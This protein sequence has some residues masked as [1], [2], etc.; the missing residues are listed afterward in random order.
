[1]MQIFVKTPTGET[2]TLEVESCAA[3]D[4]VKAKIHDK[5]GTRPPPS[6][7]TPVAF[8]GAGCVAALFV[9]LP[10]FRADRPP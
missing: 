4:T 10:R 8:A 5:E 3:V 2:M 1:M 7:M 9:I 6:P